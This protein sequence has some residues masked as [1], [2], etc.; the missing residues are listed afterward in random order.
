MISGRPH[1]QPLDRGELKHM[2]T[3]S[4]REFKGNEAPLENRAGSSIF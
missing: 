3:Y 4:F 1:E 2:N